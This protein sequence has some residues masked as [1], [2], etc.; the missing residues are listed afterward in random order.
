MSGRRYGYFTSRSLMHRMDA[1]SKF[2]WVFV[3]SILSFV[4]WEPWQLAI[5]IVVLFFIALSFS[6]HNLS[7]MLRAW[8]MFAF[9]ASLILFFHVLSRKS[10]TELL[11]LG[12]I[13]VYSDG[14][15]IGL[16]YAFRVLSIMG[17]SYIFVQTTSPRELVVALVRF[18]IPYKYAWMIFLSMLSIPIFETEA[19]I[20]REAQL[21]RGVRPASNPIQERLQM[22][23]R[24]ILPLLVSGLRRVEGLG[25]AMD[26]RGF[27][28]YPQ[29]TFIDSFHWTFS[30]LLFMGFWSLLFIVLLIARIYFI[31]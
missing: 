29:R 9:L 25:I 6:R 4:Y 27:A 20:V 31:Q 24:Y 15:K 14:L 16:M 30:G 1:M 26:S 22:Y 13:S 5:Q 21:V 11:R 18:G 3:V 28:A 2:I 23:Q 17:S 19:V 10:G 12:I 7:A 8:L